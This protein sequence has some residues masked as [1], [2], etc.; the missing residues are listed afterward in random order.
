MSTVDAPE[1]RLDAPVT[2]PRSEARR[3]LGTLLIAT[4]TALALGVLL[5]A[6]TMMGANDISRWCTVWSLLERGTYVIDECPWHAETQDKVEIPATPPQVGEDGQPVKHYYSSKPA[7]LP[8]LIAG[9]L[10]PAR[11]IVGVP[12]DRVTL[13]PREPRW[14]QV[15]DPDRPGG[16]KGVL[17]TPDQPVKWPVSSYYFKPVLIL[18]NIVPFWGFLVL[19]GRILDRRA[20]TDWAW[21]YSL[22]AAA[23]GTYLLPYSQTLNNHTIAAF[24]AFFAL[25]QF[26]RIWD[27]GAV[28]GWRFALVGL[29]AGF[30]ATNELPALAFLG[31]VGLAL[32]AR[33]PKRSLAWFAPFAVLPLL[34][35]GAC[36]YAAFGEFKLAY[37]EFGTDA[38]KFEG[39][40]WKTPL[41]LDA[42]NLPWT[43][44]EE[45]ARRG[46]VG[47]SYATYLFHMTLGHH[48]FWSSTPVF[49]VAVFGLVG[50]LWRRRPTTAVAWMTLGLT[51]ILLGFY[52]WNPKARNY[53]GSAQGLRWLFWLIPFWLLMLPPALDAIAGRPWLRRLATL[54]LFVSVMS[55]GYAMRGP[56]SNP[57]FQDMLEHLGMYSLRR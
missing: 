36:Q 48:G 14:S 40:L 24:A 13:Q 5:R 4:A 34:A 44:P 18:L 20:R 37:E 49:L 43:D 22:F 10:Y 26:L 9:L 30:T 51:V 39:S 23:F 45:A 42:L 28:E 55:V 32:V 54:A 15:P 46:I 35:L 50:L 19:F 2:E 7:L 17:T 41:E 21:S 53:G 47:E 11:Q 27:E 38:Y 6:P 3:V 16:V 12:L 33:F 8:T 31:L 52:T 29:L 56:W 25:Y 57:W 1:P